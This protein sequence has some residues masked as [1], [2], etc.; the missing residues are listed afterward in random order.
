MTRVLV[1]DEALPYPP[2]SGKRIRT[3]ELLRRLAASFE[4]VTAYREGGPPPDGAGE[5][6]GAGGLSPRPVSRRPLRKR[7]LRFG[8]DLARNLVLPVPYMVMAHRT[9]A[10]RDAV[11][12]AAV[13]FQ[14]DLVH[15]EWTPLVAN[16]PEDLGL[17]V[18]IAAHN[19]ESQIWERTL[20]NERHPLRRA[21]IATQVK[22][23]AR[24]EREALRRATRVVAVSEGDAERIRTWAGQE[25]VTVAPNGVDALTFAPRPDVAIEPESTLFVGSLDWRPNLDGV[26]FYLEAVWPRLK[27]RCPGATFTIVGRHPPAWLRERVAGLEGVRL[28]ASVPDVRPYVARAAVEVVPLRIGGGSRL[29]I[30]EALAMARPVVSTPV[31]AEGLDLEGGICLAQDGEAFARAVEGLFADPEAGRAM[32]AR[33]RERVLERHEWGRIAPRLAQAWRQTIEEAR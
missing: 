9:R 29:K 7:G 1:I 8:F 18:V 3:F 19:V 25:A 5:T 24:F 23:V 13:E 15:V 30:C 16:V 12:R 28:E 32:A 17:P 31:G 21:Y 33:G 6:V 26:V 14:P 11:R 27:S 20:E 10:M 2:D 22:K 4:I